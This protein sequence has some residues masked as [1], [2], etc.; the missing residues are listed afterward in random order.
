MSRT[1]CITPAGRLIVELSPEA[2][3]AVAGNARRCATLRHVD[4][5]DIFS[6]P[7]NSRRP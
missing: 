4:F 7:L 1:I 6:T 2:P 3:P 5:I